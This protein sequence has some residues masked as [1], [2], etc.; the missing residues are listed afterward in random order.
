MKKISII[1]PV[2]KQKAMFL[3][4]LKRNWRYIKD[5]EIIIV[6]DGSGEKLE[7]DLKKLYPSVICITNNENSGF[8]SA[9]NIGIK[10][11]TGSFLFLLN[12]DV[13]LLDS[14]FINIIEI[15]KKNKDIFAVTFPQIEKD[16]QIVG[17][18]KIYWKRG[19]FQHKK[20]SS[21]NSGYS[22]WA[23]G[24]ACIVRSDYIK[25][26]GG[27]DERFSPFYGEDIDLS[28]RALRRG[29]KIWYDLSVK[30]VH[31]HESTIG[32]YFEKGYIQEIALRNQVLY[33]WK[34][35][36]FLQKLSMILYMSYY[37]VYFL[38]KR[39]R[40]LLKGYL[41]GWRLSLCKI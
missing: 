16:D 1:I 38:Y 39:E 37:L 13:I 33:S 27:F 22:S 8:S 23:E 35:S 4:N 19:L 15:F 34:N 5:N 30:V 10:R 24:G 29:W 7:E 28:L 26:L 40:N 20:D 41:L 32:T 31:N 6:D 14:S 12:S 2:Y 9:V 36:T 18:N 25:E 11:S 17:K 21:T 3:K